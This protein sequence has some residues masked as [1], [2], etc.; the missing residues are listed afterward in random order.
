VRR[1][2]ALAAA[3]ALLAASPYAH[4][5]PK[6]QIV[7]PKGDYAVAQGDI[8]QVTFSTATAARKE[9]LQIDLLLATTPTSNIPFSYTVRFNA[10]GCTFRATY[11]GHPFNGTFEKSGVGCDASPPPGTVKID[12]MHIVF[13]VPFDAKVKRGVLIKDLAAET[14]PG[15]GALPAFVPVTDAADTGDVATGATWVVGSD[16]PKR[17]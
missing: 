2:P 8:I 15:P 7:D 3:A 11:F 9:L 14:A 1:L 17:K 13:S 6:P 16:K 5:A 12:G 4:A 10:P